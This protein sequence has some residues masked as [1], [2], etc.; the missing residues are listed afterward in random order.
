[1]FLLLILGT[2]EIANI[3]WASIQLNNAAHAGAQFGSLSRANAADTTD[4]ETA[5]QNEAPALTI[6]FPTAPTQEC[7]CITPS[8]GSAT[9]PVTCTST[10]IT[11]TSCTSPKVVLA[12]IKVTT[13]AV[14]RPAHSLSGPARHLHPARSG[15]HGDR[16]VR[17]SPVSLR[18]GQRNDRVRPL[19]RRSVHAHLRL[20]RCS[21]WLSTPTK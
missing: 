7:C 3:V 11:D 17:A 21:P 18:T 9:T 10:F 19:G 15:H 8:T 2:A 14:V 20:H 5:A 1:M 16:Q 4:M 6:T 12:S 13:Q